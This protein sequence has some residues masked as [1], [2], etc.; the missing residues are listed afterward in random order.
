MIVLYCQCQ[1]P[2]LFAEAWN[3]Y[4]NA[5]DLGDILGHYM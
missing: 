4:A 3:L 1:L 5:D 2:D